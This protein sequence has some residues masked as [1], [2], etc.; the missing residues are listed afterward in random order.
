MVRVAIAADY[1]FKFDIILVVS[2]AVSKYK[3]K[4]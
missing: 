1:V 4:T 3:K 2:A